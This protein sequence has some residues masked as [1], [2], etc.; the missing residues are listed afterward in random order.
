MK[1][2]GIYLI[3]NLTNNKVY[4]G[5]SNDMRRRASEHHHYKSKNSNKPLSRAISKYGI[6]NFSFAILEEWKKE[7][8]SSTLEFSQYL[9][10][11]EQFY[12]D[13]FFAQDFINRTNRKFRELTYNICPIAGGTRGMERS[14]E[15]IEKRKIWWA[16]HPEER[17][18][19]ANVMKL[20]GKNNRSRTGLPHSP[21]TK[22]KQAVTNVINGNSP[23]LIIT[24]MKSKESYG[25]YYGI[26]H[27]AKKLKTSHDVITA[28]LKSGIPGK[29]G[30][31]KGYVVKKISENEEFD[32]NT[33]E[34]D[35]QI[36]EYMGYDVQELTT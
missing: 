23:L 25:P 12:L 19:R 11:R 14:K 16:N 4:I 30:P 32:I 29:K 5:S 28:N 24:N 15:S 13:Q 6:T 18:K 9:Y 36:L 21:L 2:A 26:T 1:L 27:C 17:E 7:Q 22:L 34:Y 10:K 33:E 35:I 8:F 3:T 31:L 20:R